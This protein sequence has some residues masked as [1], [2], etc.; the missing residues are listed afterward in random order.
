MKLTESQLKRIIE[1]EVQR[2]I[3]EGIFDVARGLF[4]AGKYVGGKLAGAA[5][6]AG[7]AAS[8]GLSRAGSAAKAGLGKVATGV[9]TAFDKATEAGYGAVGDVVHAAG[10]SV[11]KGKVRDLET[12]LPSLIDNLKAGRTTASEETK[13]DYLVLLDM[14]AEILQD[15]LDSIEGLN[16]GLRAAADPMDAPR[17]PKR[18]EEQVDA[19]TEAIMKRISKKR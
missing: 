10:K 7:R 18:M 12:A 1:E 9:E 13:E 2:A 5:G 4:G 6:S 15:G 17:T 16:A 14:V 19:I 3:D 8:A 11:L